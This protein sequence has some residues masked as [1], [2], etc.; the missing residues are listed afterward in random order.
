[1]SSTS[2]TVDDSQD[3]SDINFVAGYALEVQDEDNP[4]RNPGHF[5]LQDENIEN[6]RK[7][8]TNKQIQKTGTNLVAKTIL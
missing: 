1:M 8:S 5:I 3:D 2:S 6:L 4:N 7:R